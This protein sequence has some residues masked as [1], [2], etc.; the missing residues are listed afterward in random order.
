MGSPIVII[1]AGVAGLTLAH[2]LVEQGADVLLVEKEHQVGGLARNFIYRNIVFDIGPHRFHTDDPEVDAYI[3]RVLG[4]N[5]LTI[6]RNSKVWFY[7][8]YHAWPLRAGTIFRLPLRI[9]ARGS[10]DIFRIRSPQ[11][12]TFRD[13]VVSRYGRTLYEHF[14]RNYTIKFIGYEP[15]ELHADWGR[16]GLDRAVID[17]RYQV[18]SLSKVLISLF[19][20][21]KAPMQFL[22]PKKGGVAAFCQA[23]REHIEQRGGNVLTGLTVS[24]IRLEGNRAVEATLSDGRSVPLSHLV[25]SAP[26]TELYRL[27]YGDSLDLEYLSSV[28]YNVII[29]HTPLQDFQWCYFGTDDILFNR[30]SIPLHFSPYNV[31]E[32]GHGICVELSTKMGNFMWKNPQFKIDR[33]IQHLIAGRL[34]LDEREILD[35]FPEKIEYTYPIYKVNYREELKK[36]MGRL[37]QI[38]NLH[39]LGRCGAFWYN[40]MDHSIAMA[41]EMAKKGLED[42]RRIEATTIF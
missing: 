6:N 3:R 18:W 17:K 10:L 27:C 38:S 39:L 2:Q 37:Q 32:K 15:S 40:N 9:M 21:P 4:E 26:I 1:G 28:I 19:S 30:V 12:H 25:W 33:I 22:Y 24:N 41:L 35:I 34:V 23:Q 14:F 29:D 31:P 11:M 20:A 5:I 13:F 36:G 16:V 8:R 7:G 42:P